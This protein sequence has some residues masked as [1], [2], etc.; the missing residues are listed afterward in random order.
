MD[1]SLVTEL[2]FITPFDNLHS[3]ARLGILCHNQ[4]ESVPHL[5]IAETSVQDLRRKVRLSNGLWLHDYA[6]LYFD[7]RNP[8]M[9]VRRSRRHAT[10]VVRVNPSVLDIPGAVVTDGNAATGGTR[11]F[12]SPQGLTH[13]DEQRVYAEWWTD[14]NP[15]D[16]A[17]RKRQRCSEVL[18]PGYVPPAYLMGCYVYNARSEQVCQS[19]AAGL[20][21]V[22]KPH[23]F[24]G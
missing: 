11:F 2:H 20:G 3:I 18:I 22:V 9:Y 24:F 5:S 7:A 21:V 16:Q 14:D 1:R 23:V 6:N 15:W 10:A 12:A 8:M 4:A 19:L 13:L 17:E